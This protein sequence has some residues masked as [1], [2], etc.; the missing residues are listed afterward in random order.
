M[1][2]TVLIP[3]L[4]EGDNLRLLLPELQTTLASMGIGFEI[5]VVDGG[6]SDASACIAADSGARVLVQSRPGYGNALREGFL[7]ARSEYVLTMDADYS[8]EPSFI[9]TLWDQREGADLIIA[10]RYVPGGRAD[11]SRLRS[12]LSR[13]LNRV[14]RLAVD[15]PYRDFSSGFRLYRME[16]LEGVEPIG[17]DFDFLPEL[18]V[19]LYADGYRVREVPFRYRPRH[20]GRSHAKLLRFGWAF[21][22]TLWRMRKLRNSVL[23]A[24]YDDRAFDSI[25]P[26]QRYWQRKR[27]EIVLSY[28]R[29]D[30]PTLDVGCGSSR[31]VTALA[32]G[33]G[34]D[35]QLKKLRYL[36][37]R[38][39]MLAAGTLSALPFRTA[40][41]RQLVCSEVIEHVPKSEVLLSEFHRVLEPGGTLVLGTPDY[42]SRI[43]RAIEWVYGLVIPGGYADEHINHYTKDGLRRELE[44]NG[45]LVQDLRTICRS[46]MIFKAVRA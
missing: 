12:F 1:H 20:R 7:A 8:H 14:Y 30:E 6:S 21:L 25:I 2:L 38:G 18:A 3:A 46:E 26:V 24:D 23:S 5:L 35:R 9:Q 34:L 28:L 22:R 15:L 43:W 42:S 16:A 41:F 37:G 10:S 19:R 31:I 29:L 36:R 27:Y 40:S 44:A 17:R 4:N 32:A 13:L 39:P 33:V 45:F 11:M